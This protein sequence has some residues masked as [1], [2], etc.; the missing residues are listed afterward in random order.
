MLRPTY[1]IRVTCPACGGRGSSGV[2]YPDH[3]E[4]KWVCTFCGGDGTVDAIA[5][6]KQEPTHD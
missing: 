4:P 3:P 5:H 1:R 2:A 6:P